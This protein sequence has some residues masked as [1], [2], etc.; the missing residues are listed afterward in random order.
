MKIASD[1]NADTDGHI[2]NNEWTFAV[3]K[4]NG[5]INAAAL[6][7]LAAFAWHG[8]R[9]VCFGF[10]AFPG[11]GCGSMPCSYRIRYFQMAREIS[12]AGC[13]DC[14]PDGS[15]LSAIVI[16][17]QTSL[18]IW[19]FQ[20]LQ[21]FVSISLFSFCLFIGLPPVSVLPDFPVPLSLEQPPPG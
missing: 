7:C 18:T 17:H 19:F 11:P 10:L 14:M 21:L 1:C 16:K 12:I 2:G 6:A 13:I 8:L 5:A 4:T 20:E 9:A 15:H 3:M